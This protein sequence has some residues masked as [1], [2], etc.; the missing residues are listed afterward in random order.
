MKKTRTLALEVRRFAM[1][2]GHLLG[3]SKGQ[4]W[5]QR[6]ELYRAVDFT[7]A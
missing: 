1:K 2:D 4:C 5:Y 3:D 7:S 6:V